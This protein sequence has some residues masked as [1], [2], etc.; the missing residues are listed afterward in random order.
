MT[1]DLLRMWHLRQIAKGSLFQHRQIS[2]SIFD[3][4]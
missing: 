3:W 1:F 2:L 4:A